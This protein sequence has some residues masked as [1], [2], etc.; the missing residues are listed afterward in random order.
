MQPETPNWGQTLFSDAVRE[1]SRG[2]FRIA[3]REHL[4]E[5]PKIIDGGGFTLLNLRVAHL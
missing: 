2:I 3:R 5:F 4:G 1:I